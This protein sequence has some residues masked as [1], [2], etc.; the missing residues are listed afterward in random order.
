MLS[1]FRKNIFFIASFVAIAVFVYFVFSFLSEPLE[2]GDLFA[3]VPIIFAVVS[4]SSPFFAS[5]AA[6]FLFKNRALSEKVFLVFLSTLLFCSILLLVNALVFFSMTEKDWE[7][8]YL[9]ALIGSAFDF[10]LE[11]Y[12]KLAFYQALISGFYF[13][14]QSF[15][16]AFLG[17][18]AANFI[19]KPKE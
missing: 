3:P 17:M 4:V 2:Q 6:I 14:V 11:E 12:K 7:N 16:S 15:G 1:F 13:V 8:N 5:L 9:G 19:A 10:S 18:V